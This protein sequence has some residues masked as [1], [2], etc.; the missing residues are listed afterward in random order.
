MS[1]HNNGPIA[2]KA[3]KQPTVTTSS[4]EAELPA[5]S[6]AA[7]ETVYA[8]RLLQA[9]EVELDGPLLVECDN[10][11]TI[12]LLTDEATK[13]STRLRHV[14]IH[15]HWLWQEVQNKR[16]SVRWVKTA[17]MVADGMTK[18][19]PRVKHIECLKQLQMMD[20]RSMIALEAQLEDA[21]DRVV[22]LLTRQKSD[23][24][25]HTLRLGYEGGRGKRPKQ[26]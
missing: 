11:N 16:I 9:L 18:A 26:R 15:Q 10:S 6:E 19:L 14:D 24:S 2:W 5:L 13:L 20:I 7:K 12:R 3:S 4:T 25:E 21:K 23:K 17:D 8:S 22:E 1:R